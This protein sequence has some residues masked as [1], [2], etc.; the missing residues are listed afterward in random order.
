MY[1]QKGDDLWFRRLIEIMRIGVFKIPNVLNHRHMLTCDNG[2]HVIQVENAKTGKT[3][4]SLPG[5]T[6]FF[7]CQWE[8]TTLHPVISFSNEKN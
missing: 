3:T 8:I 4:E 5:Q 6:C 1:E 7:Q 2:K